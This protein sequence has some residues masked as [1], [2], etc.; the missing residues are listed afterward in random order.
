[1]EDIEDFKE[2]LSEFGLI[3]SCKMVNDEVATILITDGFDANAMVT[4]RV[5][6]LITSHFKDTPVLETC[7]TEDNLCYIVLTK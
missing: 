3:K 7:I 1:M 6:G 2:K 5:M 4:M